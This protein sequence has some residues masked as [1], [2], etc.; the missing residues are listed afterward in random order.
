MES[1]R[2]ARLW[3]D[4]FLA[5]QDWLGIPRGTIR[6]TVLI[7][8]ILAALEMEEIL[9]ELREHAAG[10]G[11]TTELGELLRAR[12]RRSR[13]EVAAATERDEL[14]V[15]LKRAGVHQPARAGAAHKGSVTAAT[16]ISTP[17]ITAEKYSAL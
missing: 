15:Q 10:L 4:V 14:V 7:E 9:H 2:E 5:A 12:E 8:T 11:G 3:N 16:T 13:A 1:H 17:S 6:A